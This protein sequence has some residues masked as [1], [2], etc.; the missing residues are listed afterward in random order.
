L[1]AIIPKERA[2]CEERPLVFVDGLFFE[3]RFSN[4]F[5]KTIT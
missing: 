4:F 2:A 3:E 5:R 1:A